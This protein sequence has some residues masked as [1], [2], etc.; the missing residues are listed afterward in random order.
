MGH[1]L[2]A[3]FL[4]FPPAAIS[5]SADLHQLLFEYL[6]CLSPRGT[7]GHNS[8]RHRQSFLELF[9][10]ESAYVHLHKWGKNKG[11]GRERILNRLCAQ[12]GATS[13]DPEINAWAKIKSQRL[14]WLSYP[15]IPEFSALTLRSFIQS[16][17]VDSTVLVPWLYHLPAVWP[18]AGYS[19]FL[20][21][22]L[23]L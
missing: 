3:V 9:V 15:G 7:L 12:H 13:H 11:R 6:Y 17:P 18:Q 4:S 16:L 14:N 22:L 23:H 20:C 1:L 8:M 19:T 10:C 2:Q 21:L 5:S